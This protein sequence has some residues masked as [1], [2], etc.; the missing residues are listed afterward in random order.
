MHKFKRIKYVKSRCIAFCQCSVS[1]LSMFSRVCFV[2]D[3]GYVTD[4]C[5]CKHNNNFLNY[6]VFHGRKCYSHH[7]LVVSTQRILIY[8]SNIYLEEKVS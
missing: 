6:Y 8:K 7:S 2:R 4:Q 3:S 5:I 1:V